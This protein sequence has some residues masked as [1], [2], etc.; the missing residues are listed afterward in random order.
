MKM[1]NIYCW[2]L[3]FMFLSFII[4]QTGSSLYS[5]AIFAVFHV[6]TYFQ[7]H[8]LSVLLVTLPHKAE[9]VP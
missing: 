4:G 1:Y 7:N 8:L 6:L 9:S 5:F 2:L 3:Y